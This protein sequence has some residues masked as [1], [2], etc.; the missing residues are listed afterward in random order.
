MFRVKNNPGHTAD[1]LMTAVRL[2]P[3]EDGHHY[4]QNNNNNT[5]QYSGETELRLI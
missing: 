4:D 2:T 1:G 3:R 5:Q